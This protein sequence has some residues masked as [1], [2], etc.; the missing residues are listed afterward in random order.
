MSHLLRGAC[1]LLGLA[2]SALHAADPSVI[3]IGSPQVGVGQKFF[4]GV[5]ALAIA[6]A[7]GWIE[8]EFR[9]D[10]IEIQWVSFRGAGPAVN[11]ALANKQLDIVSLGDLAAVIGKSGGTATRLIL[12]NS[13]GANSYIAT[14]PGS[15]IKSVKD[16]KGRKVAVLLGTA[17]QRRFELLLRDANLTPRDVK[18]VSLDWP[19]SKA[20]VV[21]KDIDATFGGNDLLLLRD[22]GVGIPVSTRG[23]GGD[24]TIQSGILASEDFASK[25]PEALTRVVRQLVRAAAWASEDG[26]RDK[27]L[28]LWA[29]GSGVPLEVLQ[30]EFEGESVKTRI[31]PL[32]DEAWVEVLK[33][34]AED[35]LEQKLIRRA[36]D[37]DAWVDDR[38][39]KEALKQAKLERHWTELDRNGKP[40][41]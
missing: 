3:R 24:Y 27:A 17:Y 31:S 28:T 12:A 18:L 9:K 1:L 16:L 7:H 10:G 40:K 20:A 38:F 32:L 34:V 14:S 36:V 5:N 29:N 21:S 22:K 33:G 6:N 41:K 25:H 19:T 4:P 2:A 11:E 8:E 39:L 26:N 30:Y 15:D 37:V 23:R 13:R 35:G